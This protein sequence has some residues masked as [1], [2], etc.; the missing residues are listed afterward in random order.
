MKNKRLIFVI[1]IVVISVAYYLISPAFIVKESNE[2][3]EKV[4]YVASGSLGMSI[5]PVIPLLS[6][7]L[8]PSKHDVEGRVIVYQ[9]N[10]EKILRFEDLD[11][12]NGPSLVIYLATDTSAEDYVSLGEVRATRGNVN[13]ELPSDIDLERY[14]TVLIWCD[15]FNVL[16]SYAELK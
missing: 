16:F 15:A 1:A 12:I 14:D 8:I 11:T 10:E 6:G 9:R 13:Y 3:L 7:E 4:N 5:E 2:P